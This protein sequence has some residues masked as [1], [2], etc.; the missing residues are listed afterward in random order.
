MTKSQEQEPGEDGEEEA[1]R[2]D[3]SLKFCQ[4]IN[5]RAFAD[6]ESWVPL[7]IPSAVYQA[8]TESYR[9]LSQDF[10]RPELHE[11]LIITPRNVI[12]F[13]I[14]GKRDRCEKRSPTD[15]VVEY[16]AS[17]NDDIAAALWLAER[18]GIGEDERE[19]MGYAGGAS[20]RPDRPTFA[21]VKQAALKLKPG[22]TPRRAPTLSAT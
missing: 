5:E 1:L 20:E 14:H 21:K 15:L 13:D 3:Y 2:H 19:A 9:V 22:T 12:A 4:R 16:Y 11:T 18:L 6:L 10:S 17:I 8:K 7:L